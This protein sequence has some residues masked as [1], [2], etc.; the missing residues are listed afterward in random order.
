M[1]RG[2]RRIR[3]TSDWTEYRIELPLKP[4]ALRVVFGALLSGPGKV[5]VDDLQILVDGKPVSEAPKRERIETVL[6][7]DQ[8]FD[9]GSG[10]TVTELSGTQVSNLATLGRVWGF[11]KYHHPAV[12]DGKAHWD[13]ELFRVLPRVLE[14]VDRAA[15]NAALLAWGKGL[16]QVAACDPCA[17]LPYG[18]HLAPELD[19]IRGRSALGVERMP[20]ADLDFSS[21]RTHDLAGETFRMLSDEVAYL[22]L[23]SVDASKTSECIERAEGARGLIIDIRNYP[24]EFVVFALGQHLV[25]EPTPFVRFTHGDLS[26][27]GAFL[28]TPY[29][30]HLRPGKPRF[31][32]KVVIL[33]DEGS[34]SAA[35]Y[36]A[37]AFRAAPGAIVVGSTTVGRSPTPRADPRQTSRIGRDRPAQA[38]AVKT[39][40][41]SMMTSPMACACALG[42]ALGI[43]GYKSWDR[44]VRAGTTRGARGLAKQSAST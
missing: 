31:E 13:Y 11:L 7:T 6:D 28:W 34:M 29:P 42:T 25:A 35:E 44:K 39:G 23:S 3:G 36:T 18:L 12:D 2:R 37:M 41:R 24:S 43:N 9:E 1:P 10:V 26:N 33:V 40:S 20:I 21:G 5:W 22:K 19:W 4:E 32:G 14:A 30:L 15:A 16:G 8:E 38:R 17:A 27:P